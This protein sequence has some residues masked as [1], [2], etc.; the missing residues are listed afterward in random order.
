MSSPHGAGAIA[1][2]TTR[3]SSLC[4]RGS[5]R[6]RTACIL[7]AAAHIPALLLPRPAGAAAYRWLRRA[8]DHRHEPQRLRR[9]QL[10]AA[11]PP[12]PLPSTHAPCLAL[13]RLTLPCHAMPGLTLP[14]LALPCLA[15]PCLAWL[16]TAVPS[17]L[18]GRGATC[19]T[20]PS[21]PHPPQAR[22]CHTSSTR[23][24]GSSRLA[25]RT[26]APP[27]AAHG[28]MPG[29]E[30]RTIWMGCASLMASLPRWG[31]VAGGSTCPRPGEQ[32]SLVSSGLEWS[33]P[34]VSALM[35]YCTHN[36]QLY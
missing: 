26:A 23:T 34:S 25:S 15:L 11:R 29:R 17:L 22:C 13:P 12:H 36:V 10:Q 33:G 5:Q 21:A 24:C 28:A 1:S 7:H 4:R 2:C 6:T 20:R 30:P 14:C 8:R 27:P 31:L 3:A 9:L 35:L 19:A 18:A 32:A 16:P